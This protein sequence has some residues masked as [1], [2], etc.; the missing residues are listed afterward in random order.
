M[1]PD[2]IKACN[3][4]CIIV[5]DAGLGTI[6]GVDLTAQNIINH[7]IPLKGIIFNHYI[8]GNILHEDYIKMCE[9]ITDS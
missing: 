8:P 1:L 9:Y 5:A 6:N 4:S 7:N 3:L 2:V